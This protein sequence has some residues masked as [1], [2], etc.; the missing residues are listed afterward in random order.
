MKKPFQLKNRGENMYYSESNSFRTID[1]IAMGQFKVNSV[2]SIGFFQVT[3]NEILRVHGI[4]TKTG[5]Y[6]I[7]LKR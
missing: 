3:F 1:W 7:L 5:V 4:Y 2:D 6:V